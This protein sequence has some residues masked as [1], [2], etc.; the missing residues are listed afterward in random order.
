[1]GH[2]WP[3]GS[4]TIGDPVPLK[5]GTIETTV[6][7]GWMHL[8]VR[9]YL[10]LKAWDG[11]D[12]VEFLATMLNVDRE[13]IENCRAL[14]LDLKVAPLLEWAKTPYK[15]SF[16]EREAPPLYITLGGKKY[17]RPLT[18]G[19]KTFGQRILLDNSIRDAMKSKTGIDGIIPD[20]IAIVMADVVTDRRFDAA[21]FKEVKELAFECRL[22]DAYPMANFFFWRYVNYMNKRPGFRKRTAKKNY[23]QGSNT[24]SKGSGTSTPSTPSRS[25]TEKTG[26]G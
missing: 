12:T 21:G 6:P 2:F 22:N 11:D 10:R 24:A 17:P 5:I 15:P 9:Q 18:L 8:S 1:M 7:R 14:D 26:S 16:M 20:I 3:F 4:D 13:I 19:P 25:D 23:Q